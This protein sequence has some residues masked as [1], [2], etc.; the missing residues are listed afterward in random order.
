MGDFPHLG[1]VPNESQSCMHQR[2]SMSNGDMIICVSQYMGIAWIV[3]FCG[4][5]LLDSSFQAYVKHSK[6]HNI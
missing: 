2:I 4:S 6:F 5:N 3:K 1:D